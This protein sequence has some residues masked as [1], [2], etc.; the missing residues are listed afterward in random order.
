M[1]DLHPRAGATTSGGWGLQAFTPDD[2][3]LIHHTSLQ[4]LEDVGVKIE[5][6][7]AVEIYAGAGCR[8]TPR[9]DGWIVKIPAHVTEDCLRAAPR[10]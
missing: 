3:T 1:P 8:I 2:L 10:A 6:A 9:G 7:A 5:S 4:L